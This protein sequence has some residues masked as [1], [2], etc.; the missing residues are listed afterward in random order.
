MKNFNLATNFNFNIVVACKC[1][2]TLFLVTDPLWNPMRWRQL[3]VCIP[4]LT[5]AL[6]FLLLVLSA[7]HVHLGS[8]NNYFVQKPAVNHSNSS[9]PE[10]LLSYQSYLHDI[11]H[12]G[13]YSRYPKPSEFIS[14]NRPEYSINTVLVNKQIRVDASHLAKFAFPGIADKIENQKSVVKI[15]EIGFTSKWGALR[16]AHFVLIEGDPGSGKSTLSWRL[17]KLW[18]EGK[19]R[20]KWD[21]VVLVET[22]DETNRKAANVYDLLYHPDDSI[23]MSMAQEIQKREGEGL[24]IIFDGYD[25]L[26]NDQRSDF[27]ILKQ[28]LSNRVLEKATIVVSSRPI[29]TKGLP[30]QFKQNIDQH[31]QIVG[32]S[33]TD[34]QRYMAFACK[35]NIELLDDLRSYV[36][37]RPF[38]LSVMHNPLYCTIVTELY[39]QFWQD[40]RKGFAPNTLTDLYSAI[41]LHLLKR[42]LPLNE[43]SDIVELSHLPE[44]VN[45]SL[46]D[47]A[48]LAAKGMERRQY[49]FNNIR[50]D[51]LGLMVSVRQLYDVRPEKAA[52]RF[53]H[54]TLQQYLS[55]LYWS[56]QPQQRQIDMLQGQNISDIM[57]LHHLG[58]ENYKELTKS[59]YFD[60]PHLLFLAGLTKLTSFPLGVIMPVNDSNAIYIGPMCQLLFEAQSSQY[61]SKVF[62]NRRL[63]VDLS[64]NDHFDWFVIGYCVVNSDN[65]SSWTIPDVESP[66]ELQLLS[67]G[68][69]Y[70][71][72]CINWDQSAVR[73]AI[74]MTVRKLANEYFKIFPKLYPF[75][76]AISHL[77]LHHSTYLDDDGFS[78]LQNLSHYCPNLKSLHLLYDSFVLTE[79]PQLP[80]DSLVTIGLALPR[81]SVVFYSLHGYQKL[82]ELHLYSEDNR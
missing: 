12:M 25:E 46:M 65:T 70:S 80:K 38:I 41:F 21:L 32:F 44:H 75:T 30:A 36:S 29:A 18:S 6:F 53:L 50:T 31:I 54:L 78:V 51:T 24:L 48:E 7:W 10:S 77:T 52:Y 13:N 15:E 9:L 72:T 3:S 56:Q 34:I 28:I 16:P 66:R 43:S 74:N 60:W 1:D 57:M 27:L 47:L 35:D 59:Y 58:L 8:Q 55:A 71:N 45:S 68:L 82:R 69:H 42:S 5:V 19:L 39:I 79:T 23:R 61:V 33:E 14:I 49:I 17:C 22:I 67:D 4:P 64:L 73:L 2:C 37:S 20:Y 76:Q 11:Y 26:S 62:K 81:F 63:E 40:E